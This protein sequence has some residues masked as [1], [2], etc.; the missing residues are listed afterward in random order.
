MSRCPPRARLGR[1]FDLFQAGFLARMDGDG[2]LIVSPI[3]G[4]SSRA[5]SLGYDRLV[6]NT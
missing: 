1:A 4:R 3:A 6:G 2:R 5:P